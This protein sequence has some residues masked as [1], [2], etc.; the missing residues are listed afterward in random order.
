MYVECREAFANLEGVIRELVVRVNLL[1]MKAHHFMKGRHNKKT[2][3]F[4]KVF[5]VFSNLKMK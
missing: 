1:A 2:S 3:A 5:I 4:V